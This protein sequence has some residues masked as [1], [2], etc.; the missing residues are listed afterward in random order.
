[1]SQLFAGVSAGRQ[2]TD[3]RRQLER[4]GLV[5]EVFRLM[6][7]VRGSACPTVSVTRQF[8]ACFSGW[9]GAPLETFGRR[10]RRR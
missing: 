9:R 2:T 4:G 6:S 5:T 7:V 10:S 3:F 1:M 8:S